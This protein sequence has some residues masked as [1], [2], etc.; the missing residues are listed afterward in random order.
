MSTTSA[1]RTTRSDK[2]ES[3]SSPK[4]HAQGM[5]SDPRPRDSQA[6]RRRILD[7][8]K[9]EFSKLGFSGARVDAIA[10]SASANKRLLYLYFGSK[11]ELFRAV[12]E[13][14]Y[15]EIEVAER[16]LKLDKLDPVTAV[17]EVVKFS[18]NYYLKN[19]EF[20]A[21]VSS[22]N[23]HKA[24]QI[25]DSNVLKTLHRIGPLQSILDRGVA[26]GVF[27]PGVDV[28]QLRIT[29]AAIN[30]YYFANRF[31][32]EVMYERDF[33]KPRA[34]AERLAFNIDTIL[35]LLKP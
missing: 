13:E 34:L 9:T 6:T 32:R 10:E 8:A 24:E 18:W 2:P 21:L 1:R 35:R 12:V 5:K 3:A 17:S 27:R 7:A 26:D 19:P 25:R 31:T 20:L 22:V 11:D 23:L 33:M 29:I 15:S 28:I 16:G 4:S 14:A 30:Y